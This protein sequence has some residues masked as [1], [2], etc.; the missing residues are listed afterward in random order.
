MLTRHTFEFYNAQRLKRAV[1]LSEAHDFGRLTF[2]GRCSPV[3]PR[4]E[5]GFYGIALKSGVSRVCVFEG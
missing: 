5:V 4:K 3:V 1:M 2:R